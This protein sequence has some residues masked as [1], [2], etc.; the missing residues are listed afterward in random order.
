MKLKQTLI[1]MGIVFCVVAIGVPL[2]FVFSAIASGSNAEIYVQSLYQYPLL[3]FVSALPVLVYYKSDL[4]PSAGLALRIAVHVILTIVFVFSMMIFVYGW[5]VADWREIFRARFFL[6]MVIGLC[7]VNLV[8]VK[9]RFRRI[10]I[11]L[12]EKIHKTYKTNGDKKA[13]E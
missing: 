1:L 8:V 6:Y 4:T 12:S 5:L 9:M 13:E 10:A 7:I 3:A 11:E 2:S